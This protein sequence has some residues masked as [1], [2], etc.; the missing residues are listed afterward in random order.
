MQTA[1]PAKTRTA[2]VDKV[3]PGKTRTTE[4]DKVVNTRAPMHGSVR[5][6]TKLANKK[7]LPHGR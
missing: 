6:G 5:P 4:V 2:K 1:Y 7:G 3:M